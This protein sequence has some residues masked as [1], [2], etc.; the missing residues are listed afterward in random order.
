MGG[1]WQPRQLLG[2]RFAGRIATYENCVYMNILDSLSV[3]RV[4]SSSNNGETF[5]TLASL[6]P[7]LN[8]QNKFRAFTSSSS[9][10]HGLMEIPLVVGGSAE[11]VY[12]RSLNGGQTW[13]TTRVLSTVDNYNARVN[14]MTADG[15]NV[16]A[17]WN[18]GK[19]G[20]VFSGTIIMRRS[21]DGGWTFGP[22]QILSTNT[23]G[24]YTVDDSD[25]V[26]ATSWDSDEDGSAVYSHVYYTVSRNRGSTFCIP[27]RV[28]QT[29]F[30]TEVPDVAVGENIFLAASW[31]DSGA[32]MPS[33]V[34][35]TRS[36]SLT[37]VVEERD[38]VPREFLLAEPFPNPFNPTVTIQYS[39]PEPRLVAIDIYN[40]LGQ[41]VRGL[42]PQRITPG[43]HRVE[44]DGRDNAGRVLPSGVYVVRVQAGNR[45]QHK[46]VVYL[47]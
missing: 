33:K 39:I 19:Y 13:D 32:F 4:I 3:S 42:Q 15:N 35:F 22:E 25:N 16:Y 24:R 36:E 37:D 17:T 40:L 34:F 7:I 21:T 6:P 20:G 1:T 38:T 43:T 12:Y 28:E 5:D 2:R 44:W 46:K 11:V 30:A 10:L 47:K 45:L 29:F 8:A 23:A 26:V 27:Q 18:D 14:D 9:G 31:R 41:K